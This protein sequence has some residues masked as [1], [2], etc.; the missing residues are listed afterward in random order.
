MESRVSV[1]SINSKEIFTVGHSTRSLDEFVSVLK[2]YD[3]EVL[4]DIS[5]FPHSRHNPQFNKETLET[6]L[7]EIGIQYLWIEKLGGLERADM[8][9]IWRQRI[10][11]KD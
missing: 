10:S 1:S 5:H 11:M 9:S 4:V 2:H 6:K 7:P 8:R 3:I